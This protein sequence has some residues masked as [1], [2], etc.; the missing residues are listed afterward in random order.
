MQVMCFSM[1]R[2][3]NIPPQ[4]SQL[5]TVILGGP[6]NGKKLYMPQPESIGMILGRYEE[7]IVEAFREFIEPGMILYDVGAHVGYHSLIMHQLLNSLPYK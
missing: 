3:Y 5:S 6:L 7:H 2:F 4:P 1:T